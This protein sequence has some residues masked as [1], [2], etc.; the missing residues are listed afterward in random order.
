MFRSI[1]ERKVDGCESVNIYAPQTI[2]HNIEKVIMNTETRNGRESVE[3]E[4][5]GSD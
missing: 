2:I 3:R 4:V 1:R 5:G